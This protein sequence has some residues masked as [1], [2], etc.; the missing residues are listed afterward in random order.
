MLLGLDPY[1]RNDSNG[2]FPLFYKQL[3]RELAVSFRNLVKG[4]SFPAYWRLTDVVPMPKKSSS[5]KVGDYRPISITP[6]LSKV[7][8]KIVS[9]KLCPFLEGLLF[10]SFCIGEAWE[11]DA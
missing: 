7:F 11:H 2:I 9:G 10:L 1:G 8:E 5:W 6:V 3:V 4:S